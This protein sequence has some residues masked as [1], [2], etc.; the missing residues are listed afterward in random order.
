[1][2]SKFSVA[3]L[4]IATVAVGVSAYERYTVERE[5]AE[6]RNEREAELREL[7]L[8]AEALGA[9][10]EELQNERGLEA[11]IR[12]RFDVAKEGEQ[13]VI[14]LRDEAT[15]ATMVPTDE[16]VGG[17]TSTSSRWYERFKWWQE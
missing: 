2:Y 17:A 5:M 6:R 9:K 4:V 11:E 10:V 7:Q 12:S 1:M 8:R 15:E 16:E 13:V 14:I 3:L